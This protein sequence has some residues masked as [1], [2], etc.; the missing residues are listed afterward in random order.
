[1]QILELCYDLFGQTPDKIN[2]KEFFQI[3]RQ[4]K[5]EKYN[6][7]ESIPDGVFFCHCAGYLGGRGYN[8]F[9]D[10]SLLAIKLNAIFKK[11]NRGA[12][13]LP[14]KKINEA[15]ICLLTDDRHDMYQNIPYF[16]GDIVKEIT[17]LDKKKAFWADVATSLIECINVNGT[18]DVSVNFSILED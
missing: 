9:L 3:M 6:D 1:M 14:W 2:V 17:T 18:Y 8:N 13:N 11:Y 5:Y 15:V 10:Y 16:L 12:E 7:T 4:T